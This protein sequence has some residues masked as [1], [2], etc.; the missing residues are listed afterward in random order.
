MFV[1]SLFAAIAMRFVPTECLVCTDYACGGGRSG[2]T[3]KK[4]KRMGE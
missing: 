3:N 2:E 1:V 4:Q